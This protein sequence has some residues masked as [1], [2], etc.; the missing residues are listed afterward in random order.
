[1]LPRKTFFRPLKQA[2]N[3]WPARFPPAEAGGYGSYAGFAGGP[4]ASDQSHRRR[5]RLMS[6]GNVGIAEARHK[7][8][9]RRL[10]PVVFRVIYLG[11]AGFARAPVTIA[12]IVVEFG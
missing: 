1:M 5:L 9:S 7:N 2:P 8:R 10:T 4:E 3:S 12:A 6:R 11:E